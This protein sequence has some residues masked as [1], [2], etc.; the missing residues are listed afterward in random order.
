MRP[1][2]GKKLTISRN[3]EELPVSLWQYATDYVVGDI[4]A[5]PHDHTFIYECVAKG[6]SASRPAPGWLKE[7][8]Y[9]PGDRVTPTQANGHSL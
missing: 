1:I 4:V 7:H 2:Y 8:S 6:K 5:L 9:S 3:G